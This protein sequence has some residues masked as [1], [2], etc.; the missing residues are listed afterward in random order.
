MGKLLENDL[1]GM[2][3]FETTQY[4]RG[5]LFVCQ[6]YMLTTSYE[7]F[8]IGELELMIEFLISTI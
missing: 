3:A 8:E 6:D 4:L 7:S 1:R 5:T 2:G